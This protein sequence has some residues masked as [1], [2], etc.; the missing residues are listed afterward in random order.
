MVKKSLN[1]E[2]L[3]LLKKIIYIKTKKL[4]ENLELGEFGVVGYQTKSVNRI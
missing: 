1:I 4:Q 2:Q 3:F